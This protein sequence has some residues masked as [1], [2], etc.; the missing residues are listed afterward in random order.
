[1]RQ[2]KKLQLQLPVKSCYVAPYLVNM[3]PPRG[4]FERQNLHFK[5]AISHKLGA[6]DRR[7][8]YYKIYFLKR[9]WEIT[10]ARNHFDILDS[11]ETLRIRLSTFV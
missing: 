6:Y 11:M 5:S 4:G 1:M 8:P 7:I 10:P 2:L 9:F 3:V